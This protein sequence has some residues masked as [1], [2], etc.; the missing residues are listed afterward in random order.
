MEQTL[1]TYNNL[2]YS[3]IEI[4]PYCVVEVYER[5]VSQANCLGYFIQPLNGIGNI[6]NTIITRAKELA[7]SELPN[8]TVLAGRELES[9]DR[10]I[11][12]AVF[13]ELIPPKYPDLPEFHDY[14]EPS[15]PFDFWTEVEVT[16]EGRPAS[17]QVSLTLTA[18]DTPV[19][20]WVNDDYFK[21][22]VSNQIPADQKIITVDKAGVSYNSIPVNTFKFLSVPKLKTGINKIKVNKMTV[23]NVKV[24][25]VKKF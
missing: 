24:K 4:G 25:Y 17:C 22:D 14:G 18:L 20:F 19:E 12:Y 8:I 10:R 3:P 2:Q 23:S 16:N 1:T 15:E 6:K 9:W 5:E 21:I 11:V 7:S 13:Y